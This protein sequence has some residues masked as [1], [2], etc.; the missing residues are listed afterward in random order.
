MTKIAIDEEE[1]KLRFPN[2]D[3]FDITEIDKDV[4]F[5]YLSLYTSYM[6]SFTEYLIKN[7]NI[8]KYD[9][10][11]LS[12]NLKFY[13]VL[14]NN[15]DVYQKLNQNLLKYFYIRNNIYITRLSKEELKFLEKMSLK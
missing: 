8:K 11:L 9:D 3:K 10:E 4:K 1:Y 14:Y 15:K 12:S 7:T 2:F 13:P 5:Y 6:K